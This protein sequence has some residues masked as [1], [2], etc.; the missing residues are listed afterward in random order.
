MQGDLQMATTCAE[1]EVPGRRHN[2]ADQGWLL[3]LLL[4]LGQLGRGMLLAEAIC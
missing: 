2:A 4:G 1:V 3:L